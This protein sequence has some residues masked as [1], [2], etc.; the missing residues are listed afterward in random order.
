[1][2]DELVKAVARGLLRGV[3]I[4]VLRAVNPPGEAP[5]RPSQP[6]RVRGKVKATKPQDVG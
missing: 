4:G 1:M 3:L 2:L 6:L 5:E